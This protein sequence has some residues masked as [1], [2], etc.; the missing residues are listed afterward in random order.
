[1]TKILSIICEPNPILHQE[2]EKIV[3]IT[4]DIITFANRM[5]DT[6]KH[7]HGLGLAAVQ[8]SCLK[9]IIVLDTNILNQSSTAKISDHILINAQILNLSKER[10]LFDEGCLSFKSLSVQT[11]RYKRVALQYTNIAGKKQEIHFNEESIL[12]A[13]IQHEVDHTNGIVFYQRAPSLYQRYVLRKRYL[14]M[15]AVKNRSFDYK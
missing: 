9:K 8:V 11:A 14:R 15:L 6:M 13:C 12:S 7:Y 2:S 10:F 4:G 1:M 3:T 5:Y